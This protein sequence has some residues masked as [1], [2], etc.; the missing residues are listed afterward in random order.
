[1]RWSVKTGGFTL[2]ELLIVLL[3]VALGT[4]L[5]GPKLFH[6]YGKERARVE[7]QDFIQTLNMAAQISFCQR[8]SA[9]VEV[10]D[11]SFFIDGKLVKKYHYLNFTP[12]RLTF[13]QNG[14]AGGA[15]INYQV[16]NH[17]VKVDVQ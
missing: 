7:E 2:I 17:V 1:M 15:E 14:F 13:N 8:R 4:S 11:N 10:V 6:L 9:T 3:I 5:V 16:Q 12:S